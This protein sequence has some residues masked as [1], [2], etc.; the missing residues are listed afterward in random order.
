MT[1][2]PYVRDLCIILFVCSALTALLL[3]NFVKARP[4]NP[5]ACKSYLKNIATAL[6]MYASDNRGDYPNSLTQLT[7]N[8]L[9]IIPNCPSAQRDTYSESYQ[10]HR[11]PDAFSLLCSGHNHAAANTPPGYPQYSSWTGLVER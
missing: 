11:H 8:Y 7:P 4:Q 9:K 2:H 10:V 6:E 3:P 5:G 1:I